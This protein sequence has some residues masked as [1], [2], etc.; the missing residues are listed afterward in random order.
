MYKSF[1][2]LK[3]TAQKTSQLKQTSKSKSK[4]Q[5][6]VMTC[7][8]NYLFNSKDCTLFTSG[9][10]VEPIEC[11]LTYS[12]EMDKGC[13]NYKYMENLMALKLQEKNNIGS[14]SKLKQ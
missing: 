4:K 6:Y 11:H 1:T 14:L 9:S 3:N 7:L 5:S 10:L 13:C 12:V 2:Y 8:T